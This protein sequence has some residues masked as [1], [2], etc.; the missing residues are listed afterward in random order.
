MADLGEKVDKGQFRPKV[1]TEQVSQVLSEA[2]LDGTLKH[3]EQLVETDLQ[4]QLG[5]SRSPLREAFRD[6]EKK[7]LVVIIPRRGTFVREI[8][9]ADVQEHFPVRAALE[10]L[11]AREA[12]AHITGEQLEQ[13]KQALLGMQRAGELGDAELYRQQHLKFHETFIQASGNELLIGMLG[14]LRM[15]RLW[16]FVSYRYHRADF[17]K[18]L[19]VHE[20]MLNLFAG[21]QT[22]PRELEHVVRSH[23]DEALEDFLAYMQQHQNLPETAD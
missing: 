17:K 10:G 11:A 6:L 12:Y 15:H 19:E 5:I 2:I 1:L 8:T 4:K 21:A 7:G 18:A 13:M 14:T 22:D 20:K 16:F 9:V 23:I 3:G